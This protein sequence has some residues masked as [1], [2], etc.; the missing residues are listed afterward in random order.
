[1]FCIGCTRP[2]DRGLKLTTLFSRGPLLA[3][4]LCHSCLSQFS[5]ITGI[6]CPGCGR[7]Q[8]AAEPCL[9]CRKWAKHGP[10]LNNRALVVYDAKMKAW[11]Y[12]Y[13]GLGDYR[14]H[15]AFQ[16]LIAERLRH[17]EALVPIPSEAKHYEWRG[18]D[19]ILGLFGC[20]PLQNW[21]QKSA[22]ARPQAQKSRRERLK[23]PQSFRVLVSAK[24]LN[25]VRQITL[26][27][28]LYT[29]GRT[30]YHARDA[31]EA[32]GFKGTIR[33]FTLIR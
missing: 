21:L 31:L 28:D 13:K 25:R 27:D 3:P 24:T 1:M 5:F 15:V 26:L 30:L 14:L 12:Q 7:M 29:T 17:A 19:P 10:L 4:R 32:A 20:L 16:D 6:T 2:T 23:T 33:A 18:F 11:I 9:D 22:T 8:V